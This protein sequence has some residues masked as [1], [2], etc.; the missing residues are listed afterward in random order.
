MTTFLH[1]NNMMRSII[2]WL[3]GALLLVSVVISP[4]AEVTVLKQNKEKPTVISSVMIAITPTGG[5]LLVVNPDSNSLTFIDTEDHSVLHE[6]PVGIDP[7]SLAIS[8]DGAMALVANQGSDTISIVDM[9]ARQVIETL[10]V[11]DRPIGVVISPDSETVAV[12]EFGDDQVRILDYDTLD[13]VALLPVNDRPY[14][15]AFSPDGH[16]LLVTHLLSGEVTIILVESFNIYLPLSLSALLNHYQAQGGI[17]VN[18]QGF[19]PEV[20]G[21]IPTL[22]KVAP[23]PSLIV[24]RDG[25][26]VYIP[27]T[28]GNGLGLNT[29]FD[30]TVFPKVSVV[31][32]KTKSYDS[33]EL[34]SLDVVDTPVG[35]PWGL[36]LTKEDSELWVTN[37]GS[38]DISV[39]NITDPRRPSRQAHIPVGEN[40][41]GVVISLD[42]NTAYV[43]N[44]LSGTVSMIDTQ[45]YTVTKVITT[46][47]IPLPPIILQ[48]KRLFH[49][50]SRP[51]LA[52]ARW[53]SCNTCHIEGEQDG[54]TWQMRSS[55]L[56]LVSRNTT[57]LLG[58]IETYPLRWTAEWD[59]SADSEFAICHEQFGT[60]LIGC[61]DMHPTLGDPNQGRSADL[62]AL[63]A[64]IDGLAIPQRSHALTPQEKRGKAVFESPEAGCLDCHSPPLYTDLMLHNVGTGEVLEE[65]DTPTLRFLFDSPPYLHDGRAADLEEV[66]TTYNQSD[67]HGVSS[68]L[69]QE[70]LDDLVTYLLALPYTY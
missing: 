40:P 63:A 41:R 28:M 30:T 5:T 27:Q 19:Q 12:A 66:L 29:Q 18:G 38:N 7:R 6:L 4:A 61:K 49:S 70:E 21:T 8:P 56:D 36:A 10:P 45:T 65:Y 50:S 34:I 3:T 35:L 69:T 51:E 25:S 64:F 32:L 43:N 24:S 13:L 9:A 1:S 60:G 2:N 54:R 23:A 55:S 48:G 42:G 57:S 46:T 14:G 11:G 16:Y 22:N 26:R 33:S 37:S 47:N 31:D 53:I 20:V 17:Q 52:R 67:L 15:L 39:I 59:E 68:H 62:D 44:T 58:M